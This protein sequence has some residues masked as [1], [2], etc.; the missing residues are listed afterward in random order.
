MP[1][2]P[3]ALIINT[4]LDDRSWSQRPAADFDHTDAT[5]VNTFSIDYVGVF[6]PVGW[7]AATAMS[8]PTD[9]FW[10]LS[11]GGKD[12]YVFN[13][14]QMIEMNVLVSALVTMVML[15]CFVCIL[16]RCYWEKKGYAEVKFEDE[17]ENEILNDEDP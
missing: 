8:S 9:H 11:N 1:Y 10:S 3:M 13:I 15:C 12:S 16:K 5:I 14:Y 7:T 2:R 4:A 17:N 6:K